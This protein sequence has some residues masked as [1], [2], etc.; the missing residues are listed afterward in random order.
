MLKPI[1]AAVFSLIAAVGA[2][3]QAYSDVAQV[4]S[5]QPIY[6]RVNTP[7][8]N[9]WNETVSYDRRTPSAY[10]PAQYN[11]PAPSSE[12]TVG[13]GTILGAVIGGVVG[14]QFGNSSRGR[15]HGTVAGAVV[16]GI[17]GNS[18]ENSQPRTYSAN[19]YDPQP[20][21]VDYAPETRSVQRCE[22][23]NESREEISG[24]NVTYRYNGRDYTT[25]MPYDPGQTINVRVNL[26][27]EVRT[28][29]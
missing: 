29:R 18:I 8:Q 21:R 7:R 20:A 5:A 6:E 27:P 10:Q 4:V 28:Y 1:S 22:T 2:S 11:A 9:C 3:A 23:V 25:R 12:R 13:A 26:A 15:D 16:G 19:N 24:Y 14:H 17:V